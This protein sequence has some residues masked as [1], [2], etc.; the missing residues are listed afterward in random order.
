MFLNSKTEELS[1]EL[2]EESHDDMTRLF[3]T[4]EKRTKIDK[5]PTNKK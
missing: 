3:A 2:Y 1:I 5:L 4:I